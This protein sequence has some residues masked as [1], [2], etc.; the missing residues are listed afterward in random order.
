M[1]TPETPDTSPLTGDPPGQQT[2]PPRQAGAKAKRRSPRWL[3]ILAALVIGGVAVWAFVNYVPDYVARHLINSELKAMGIDTQGVKTLNLRPWNNEI[4]MGPV[5][6]R[7]LDSDVKPA[8]VTRLGVKYDLLQL[9]QRRALITDMTIT[10]I[11][12]EI[13]R[14]ADGDFTINGIELSR[15]L[16]PAPEDEA[17]PEDQPPAKDGEGWG[18]GLDVLILTDSR[19]FLDDLT[20]GTLTFE[21]DTLK[22]EGFR[23]WAPD[24]PGTF[25]LTGRLNDIDIYATGEARPF[26][27]EITLSFVTKVDRGSW[28]KV[29]AYT[30][31]TF[32]F[33]RQG[34]Q[35]SSEGKHQL[36]ITEDGGLV[37]YSKTLFTIT[38]VVAA[39]PDGISGRYDKGVI[40]LDTRTALDENGGMEVLGSTT[41]TI[42]G[43]QLT[44][45]D[46]Q[47]I[48]LAGVNAI[49][50]KM[51]V[52]IAAGGTANIRLEP[53]FA[54]RGVSL[55]GPA[56]G[57]LD[58]LF[59]DLGEVNVSTSAN[60]MTMNLSGSTG[61]GGLALS[62]PAGLDL[63]ALQVDLANV[64]VLQQGGALSLTGAATV[65]AQALE[66]DLPEQPGQP[67]LSAAIGSL[68]ATLSD[69]GFDT[70]AA[71]PQWRTGVNLDAADLG[72][73]V[74]SGDLAK[75]KAGRV[76]LNGATVDQSM[77]FAAAELVIATL[78]AELSDKLMTAFGGGEEKTG[79]AEPAPTVKLARLAFVDGARILYED[80]AVDPRVEVSVNARTLEID[81]IDT[82]NPNQRTDAK[83]V[84]T[85]NEFATVDA[86]GWA[87][88]LATRPTFDLNAT[89]KGLQLVAFSPYAAEAV[90]MHL[91]SGTLSTRTTA[92][93]DQGK[94]KALVKLTLDDL[95]FTPVS[96]ADA[97]RLSARVGIPVE[98][99]VAMLQDPDG[100]IRLELPVSG[101]TESPEIDLSQ[102]IGKAI[103]GAFGALVGGG[104]KDGGVTFN[105]ITFEAGS[106][107]LEKDGI[108]LAN[109]LAEMLRQRP[110]LSVDVCGRVTSRDLLAYANARGIAL[111]AAPAA[112]AKAAPAIP[113]K[114]RVDLNKLAAERTR[115]VRQFVSAG[116]GIDPSRI[117]E[118]RPT[119]DPTDTGPPR[120]DIQM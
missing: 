84:A 117:E 55:D 22:L 72:V 116:H 26:G 28:E 43:M 64:D 17:P 98:T 42:D 109:S 36:D 104:G 94:L 60:R 48:D 103:G 38:D 34:G 92:A 85:V 39:R 110:K 37:F 1:S 20:R 15:F 51:K 101:T 97:E 44:L 73:T 54:V 86:S 82:G 113:E 33:E 47:V 7:P 89:V 10:G 107:A 81:N 12:I 96:P 78:Q 62:S 32:D 16:A 77:A 87:E 13:E 93:A 40:T 102:V 30:G 49:F 3:K 66:A 56:A 65:G 115:A 111:P 75:A 61:I 50:D 58:H 95:D 112:G 2:E 41:Y 35:F 21:L 27:G 18:A 106:T 83:V 63:A 53:A 120:V 67:A 70:A 76:T 99:A 24:N 71:A 100:A 19:V 46:G 68:D 114:A 11:D 25:E 9:F 57:S 80:T 69:L 91:D 52:E 88:P 45:P 31:P 4:W 108:A 29:L 14:D 6:L 119:F 8:A 59:I 74:G 79:S 105:P 90:G 118:C 5:S 23:T